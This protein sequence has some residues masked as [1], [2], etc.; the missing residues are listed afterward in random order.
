MMVECRYC[1]DE[2]LASHAIDVVCARNSGLA[3]TME[4]LWILAG[5][6]DS[7]STNGNA[8]NDVSALDRME[9]GLPS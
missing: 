2:C 9:R 1:N 4:D 7:G 3:R 5:G 6:H 8:N